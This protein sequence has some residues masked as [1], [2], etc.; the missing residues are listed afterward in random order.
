MTSS[1]GLRGHHRRT[2]LT[3]L[4]SADYALF[5]MVR[6]ILLR[7]LRPE[8]D[9]IQNS[10]RVEFVG[11]SRNVHFSFVDYLLIYTNK[12]IFFPAM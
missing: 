1:S 7:P 3:I 9:V 2:Y 5:K 4:K 12:H 10:C 8:L 6:Y 11:I